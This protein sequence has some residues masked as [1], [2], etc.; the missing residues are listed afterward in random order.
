MVKQKVYLLPKPFGLIKKSKYG[1]GAFNVSIFEW[2][3][4]PLIVRLNPDFNC[5]NS[6]TLSRAND[7]TTGTKSFVLVIANVITWF[8]A[9]SNITQFGEQARMRL[10]S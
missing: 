10:I 9:A 7:V 4:F 5:C 2:Y 1:F 6:F 3:L 8:A